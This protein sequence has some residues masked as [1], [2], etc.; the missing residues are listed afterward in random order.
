MLLLD[1]RAP[2][3]KHRLG[4]AQD[5]HLF[6]STHASNV[7]CCLWR[8]V[9]AQR[10]C[11]FHCVTLLPSPACLFS[12]LQKVYNTG[13]FSRR[14][15]SQSKPQ[16]LTPSLPCLWNSD[17]IVSFACL[18]V[19]ELAEAAQQRATEAAASR[20]AAAA[21]T[22]AQA[23]LAA[24]VAADAAAQ[25][26]LGDLLRCIE[27]V[28][29][30]VRPAPPFPVHMPSSGGGV[31]HVWGMWGPAAVHRGRG[32][33]G[34]CRTARLPSTSDFPQQ[35]AVHRNCLMPSHKEI[36]PDP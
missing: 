30:Q 15:E 24:L 4:P 22:S 13:N 26:K 20:A 28:A 31:V 32:C 6:S 14:S 3:H 18:Q 9:R 7:F 25:E 36:M 16:I 11:L 23:L 1:S 29:A 17:T 35:A 34:G 19:T 33:T 12:L 5:W 2:R 21:E 10:R 8:W 27:D